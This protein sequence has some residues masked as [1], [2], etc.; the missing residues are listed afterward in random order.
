MSKRHS[1]PKDN[2]NIVVVK[3]LA[4]YKMLVHVLRFGNKVRDP[5]QYREVM[6][7]LIGHLEGEGEIKIVNVEDA[8]PVSHGGSIEINFTHEQL[9]A[10]G[11]IDLKVWEI[12]GSKNWFK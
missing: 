10:F 9:G 3:P 2:E 4:Y 8:V 12:Y 7:M 1:K 11:E 6:G 5:S